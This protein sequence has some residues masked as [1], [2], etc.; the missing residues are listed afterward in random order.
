MN[1]PDG[2]KLVELNACPGL[3]HKSWD[4]NCIHFYNAIAEMLL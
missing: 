4:K 1:S 3:L 2:Y